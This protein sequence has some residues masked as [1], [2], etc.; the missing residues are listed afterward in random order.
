MKE[1]WKREEME[2]LKLYNKYI[3]AQQTTSRVSNLSGTPKF[4]T[5]N[6]QSSKKDSNSTDSTNKAYYI[7]KPAPQVSEFKIAEYEKPFTKNYKITIDSYEQAAWK[8][9]LY[10]IKH[11][12]KSTY[13]GSA[14]F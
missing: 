1:K 6:K 9:F 4:S 10:R 13:N 11:G 7:P 2:E 5:T 14:Y 8:W 12:I 3:K